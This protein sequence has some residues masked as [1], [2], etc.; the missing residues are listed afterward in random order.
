MVRSA[1]I[2]SRNCFVGAG[3]SKFSLLSCRQED[4][5]LQQIETGATRAM[6]HLRNSWNPLRIQQKVWGILLLV[7]LPLIAALAGHVTLLDRLQSLQQQHHQVVLARE[8]VHILRRLTVDIEDAFR[9]YLLTRQDV[10]LTPMKD[11]EPKLKPTLDRIVSLAAEVPGLDVNIQVIEGRINRL[12]RSKHEL[13][14]R[15]RAGHPDEVLQYVQSG[16]GIALSDE[17]REHF[18][19]LEDRIVGQMVG[20]QTN[21]LWLAQLAFWGLVFAVAGTVGL[22][23]IGARL[24]ARS[25]TDPIAALQRSVKTF[26]TQTDSDEALHAIAVRTADEIGRLAYSYLEMIERIRQQ[27]RELEALSTIGHEINAI[28][29]DGLDGVLRRITDHA[30][31][32]LKADICLVMLRNEQMGCWIVEAASGSWNDQLRKSVMLWEEFP[33]SVQA[34]ETKQPAIGE[35]LR[36]DS[37]PEVS[38]RNLIGDSMLAIPLLTQGKAFGVLALLQERAVPREAWNLR[39]AKGFAD[40]AAVA[41]ANARLYQEA[42]QKGRDVQARIRELEYLAEALAHDLKAPG[43]RVEGLAALVRADS[44]S[45]LSEQ[46]QQWVSLI[47]TNG[48]ELRRRVEHILQVAR[49]GARATAVEAVDP[50]VV[51]QD[52]LKLRAGELERGQVRVE[53][54]PALPLVACHGAYLR[55]VFDNIISNAIKFTGGCAEP[56]IRITWERKGEQVSFKVSDNGCGI[57]PSDQARVF[58]PFVR[59]HADSVPGSGIGLTIVKRIV[60]LYGG[61]VWIE[62]NPSG[63]CSVCFT[64]PVLG[65]LRH[66]ARAVTSDNA[67]PPQWTYGSI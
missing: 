49:I 7:F 43:E 32:L 33:I 36:R 1:K 26:G 12:L 59:L 37:R 17:L 50:A 23:L 51:L 64:I 58:E 13:L 57:A 10:F 67:A 18:R 22:G 44:A 5:R 4:S 63:G 24:L 27:I 56:R 31:D 65:E 62:S 48:K 52:V 55:Q 20:M 45:H 34:F 38:R 6:I 28:G 14:D 40:E 61:R 9:G 66:A 54:Q 60:E 35:D 21:Q 29:P 19:V 8:Q 46:A 47:E 16:Q 42:Q 53:V 2:K 39:L 15:V 11:A 41:I 25:I 30:A 3:H